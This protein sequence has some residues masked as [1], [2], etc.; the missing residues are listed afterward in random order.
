MLNETQEAHL[1]ALTCSTAPAGR[2]RWTLELLAQQLVQEGVVTSIS[3]ETVRLILK[4]NI[5]NPGKFVAGAFP[6]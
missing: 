3:P 2:E 1:V 5:S 6:E 4:K